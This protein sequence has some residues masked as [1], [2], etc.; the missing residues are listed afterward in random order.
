M[1]IDG[2]CPQGTFPVSAADWSPSFCFFQLHGT[3]GNTK[4]PPK[5][6][7]AR[8]LAMSLGAETAL[9]CRRIS[10]WLSLYTIVAGIWHVDHGIY[11]LAE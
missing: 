5:E 1:L 7:K 8:Y 11:E 9:I 2:R 10:R 6:S 4:Q 3:F